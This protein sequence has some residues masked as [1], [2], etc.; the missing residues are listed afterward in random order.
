MHEATHTRHTWTCQQISYLKLQVLEADVEAQQNIAPFLRHK[1]LRDVVKSFTNS[2]C[3]D[4]ESWAKNQQVIDMLKEA[5]RLLDNGYITEQELENSLL[6]QLQ[7]TPTPYLDECLE[8]CI[9]TCCVCS[10]ILRPSSHGV[11]TF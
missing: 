5:Q 6:A 4:F 3:N 2:P 9:S 7:V 11:L 1:V 10:S 8:P